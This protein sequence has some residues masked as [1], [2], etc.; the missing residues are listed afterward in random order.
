MPI[1]I[2]VAAMADTR[3][4]ATNNNDWQQKWKIREETTM[5]G[6]NGGLWPLGNKQHRLAAIADTGQSATNNKDRQQWLTIS[7]QQ[8]W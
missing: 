1:S 8:Q 2:S 6:S 3:Q 4:S 5:I 7:N